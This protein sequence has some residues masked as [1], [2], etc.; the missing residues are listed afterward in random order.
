M[1]AH[2]DSDYAWNEEDRHFV[3]VAATVCVGRGGWY[4]GNIRFSTVMTG[5]IEAKNRSEE[6]GMLIQMRESIRP[7]NVLDPKVPVSS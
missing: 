6:M 7:H 3:A 1:V 2:C 5:T 4:I